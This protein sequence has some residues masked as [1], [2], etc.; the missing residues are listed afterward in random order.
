LL[1]VDSGCELV[2]EVE[3]VAKKRWAGNFTCAAN[4]ILI[5]SD[6]SALNSD[7]LLDRAHQKN[8][9]LV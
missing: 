8:T 6:N 1:A 4:S 5:S 3:L 9:K 7:E 2:S